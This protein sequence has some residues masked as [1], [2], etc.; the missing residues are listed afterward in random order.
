MEKDESGWTV[1]HIA[2]QKGHLNVVKVI[3]SHLDPDK[4]QKMYDIE[5]N[6]LLHLACQSNSKD[7][8]LHLLNKSRD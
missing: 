1:L 3:E 8:V 2:C 7:V 5:G 6:T 4:L